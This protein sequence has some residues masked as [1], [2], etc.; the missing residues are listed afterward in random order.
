MRHH[1]EEKSGV[2]ESCGLPC[3]STV[4][5]EGLGS[6]EYWGSKGVHHAYATVSD[7][8]SENILEGSGKLIRKGN[9][10]AKK[11]RK[12]SSGNLIR[13]GETYYFE[14]YRCYR[15][16]GPSWII[17]K[18]YR[19]PVRTDGNPHVYWYEGD[20]KVFGLSLGFD[21]HGYYDVIRYDGQRLRVPS[22]MLY[23]AIPA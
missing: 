17:E 14:V 13:K 7:C 20:A 18:T 19:K 21:R 11:D 10:I 3:E 5:D 23:N 15:K 2:C 8:C 22:G 16:N 6:Y 12:D 9:R 1:F 4:V